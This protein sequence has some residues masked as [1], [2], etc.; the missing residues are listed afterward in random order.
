MFNFN[1]IIMKKIFSFLVLFLLSSY[2]ATDVLAQGSADEFPMKFSDDIN[3]YVYYIGFTRRQADSGGAKYWTVDHEVSGTIGQEVLRDDDKD[4]IQRW[5]FVLVGED[6]P[7]VFYIQNV[8]SDEF[9]TYHSGSAQ[10]TD[11]YGKPIPVGDDRETQDVYYTDRDVEPSKFKLEFRD[12]ITAGGFEGGWV[13]M[14]QSGSS[15]ND[16]GAY[17]IC[18]YGPDGGNLLTFFEAGKPAINLS[19]TSLSLG[20]L[21][22]KKTEHFI[23]VTGRFLTEDITVSFEGADADYF[24]YAAPEN[25]K[26]GTLWIGFTPAELRAHTATLKLE[27]SGAVVTVPLTGTVYPDSDMP[28]ISSEDDTEEYW[29]FI[30]FTG[31]V[32]ENKAWATTGANGQVAQEVIPSGAAD[33]KQLWKIVGDW[34]RGFVF[35]NKAVGGELKYNQNP[36]QTPIIEGLIYGDGNN[37]GTDTYFV[38]GAGGGYGDLFNFVRFSTGWRLFNRDINSAPAGG[39]RLPDGFDARYIYDRDGVGLRQTAGTYTQNDIVF[40]EY[41]PSIV[42]NINAAYLMTATAGETSEAKV[43]VTGISTTEG[44]TVTLTGDAVFSV[45]PNSLPAAGGE[46]TLIFAPDSDEEFYQ[47]SLTL[48]SEGAD[49]VV[50]SLTGSY[51]GP[52]FS[53]EDDVWHVL[54]FQRRAANNLVWQGNGIG[55]LVTQ[56]ARDDSKHSQQWRFVGTPDGLIIENREGGQMIFPNGNDARLTEEGGDTYRYNETTDFTN[57]THSNGVNDRGSSTLCLYGGVGDDGNILYFYPVELE[58][59]G[60][61]VIKVGSTAATLITTAGQS[62]AVTIE[63]STIGVTEAITA[64]LA[65]EGFTVDVTSIP[66]EGGNITISFNP[67]EANKDYNATLT[68]T[69]SQADSDAVISILGKS[70][71]EFS[72]DD[73]EVWYYIQ[74]ERPLSKGNNVVW[75][76]HGLEE[77]VTQEQAVK[78]QQNQHW[79]LVGEWDDQFTIVNREGGE[80]IFLGVEEETEG[81]LGKVGGFASLTDVGYG[82]PMAF[83]PESNKWAFWIFEYFYDEDTWGCLNDHGGTSTNVGIYYTGDGGSYVTFIPIDKIDTAIENPTIDPNDQVVATRYYTIQGV[84]VKSP[85]STG[86]YIVRKLY[87]SGKT[88]AVKQ[89]ILVK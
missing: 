14:D 19:A 47:A 81:E 50:I 25:F 20:S 7:D 34:E 44:I 60:R 40:T 30:Q 28:K 75:Q 43:T 8:A 15:L 49:D 58:K 61:K 4:L 84:E 57:L 88:Q 74:F 32:T 42:T 11:S 80:I 76:G 86:I 72:T 17:N 65:G 87:A 16:R 33:D 77:T 62:E 83:V 59:V 79:K 55:E 78:D 36:D 9:V 71:P 68:L 13:F 41:K 12:D 5:K 66:A 26:K 6:E 37:T 67:T 56:A 31:R 39:T 85:A 63:V 70:T 3:E 82:D 21:V 35:I 54:Q 46:L 53:L 27:S 10:F 22:D 2:M 69:N 89:L 48:S 52:I 73:N 1:A 45:S 38:Y 29:Y 18:K 64:T 51:G 23:T 24:S